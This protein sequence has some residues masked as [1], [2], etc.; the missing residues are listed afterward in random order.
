MLA[1]PVGSIFRAISR[2]RGARSLHPH[3]F[4]FEASV[5]ID[6]PAPEL[7]DVPL[8]GKR[9]SHPAI[10]R[11]SRGAGVPLALPDV[12]G[13]AIRIVDAHGPSQHQDFLLA[14]SL[15]RY[16]LAPARGFFSLPYS[17][18]LLY[19]M[20]GQLRVVGARA[21]TTAADDG[22]DPFDQLLRTAAARDLGFTLALAPPLGRWRPVGTIEIGRR[23]GEGNAEAIRFN[24]WNCGGGIVPTGPFMGIRDEAYRES[25]RGYRAA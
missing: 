21:A 4:V 24:P 6:R 16:V 7:D 23:L 18:I 8:L 12:H 20:A 13:L 14:T 9:G 5:E 2:V 19:R 17:S 3:G 1:K 15:R 11:L 10:A 25:Q 22:R